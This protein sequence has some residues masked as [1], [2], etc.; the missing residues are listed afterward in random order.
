[1][2]EQEQETL[3]SKFLSRN[4]VDEGSVILPVYKKGDKTGCSNYCGYDLSGLYK[5][6]FSI[7]PSDLCSVILKT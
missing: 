3:T 7:L 6:L 5:I 4:I 2:G 1:M